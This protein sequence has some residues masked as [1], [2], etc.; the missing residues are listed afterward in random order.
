MDTKLVER[1]IPFVNELQNM[2]GYNS[3]ITHLLYLIIPAFVHKYSIS[4][5]NLI[6]NTFRQ[7]K[8]IISTKEHKL[9][10]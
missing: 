6:I 10:F 2:Y 4:K 7:T 5:E 9:L 1:Y 8:I 3:N